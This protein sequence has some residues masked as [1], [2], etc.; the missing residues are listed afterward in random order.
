MPASALDT[1][2]KLT[3]GFRLITGR[4]EGSVKF[5]FHRIDFKKNRIDVLLA[6]SYG[7]KNALEIAA[8]YK[9]KFL[10]FSSSVVYG[11]R[12]SGEKKVKESDTGIVDVLSERSS[13]DEGSALL[14]RW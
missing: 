6:N 14:K 13:Y 7:V 1:L 12:T 2:Y 11:H 8:L 3:D 10:H 9:A 5:E 4:L